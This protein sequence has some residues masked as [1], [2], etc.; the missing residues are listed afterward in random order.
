VTDNQRSTETLLWAGAIVTAAAAIFFPRI[1][2]IRDQDESWWRLAYF[3]VPQDREGVLLIPIV[4]LLTLGL[5]AIVGRRAWRNT[6]G[7]NRPATVGVVC[8]LL[9]LVGVLVFFLS[10]PILLGGLGTTLGI[11]GRRR[12]ATEG[13]GALALA[14]VVVG[15]VAFA[16]GASV[17]A[18]AEELGI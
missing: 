10:A 14:A 6:G 15:L 7:R 3:F 17:W 5:F 4:I 12:A 11:E 2:G 8:S 13:R 18:F 9:G 16:I 1:Q